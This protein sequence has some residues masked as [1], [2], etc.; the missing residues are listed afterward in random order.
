MYIYVYIYIYYIYEHKRK[1]NVCMCCDTDKENRKHKLCL[2]NLRIF[3]I[4]NH[5]CMPVNGEICNALNLHHITNI[6]NVVTILSKE[7]R[8]N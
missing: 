6:T 8:N 4:L 7:I 2:M 3:L 1:T 5:V